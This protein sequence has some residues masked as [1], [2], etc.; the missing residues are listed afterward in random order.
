ML[1]LEGFSSVRHV[2]GDDRLRAEVFK[3]FSVVEMQEEVLLVGRQF[4]LSLFRPDDVRVFESVGKVVDEH[5]FQ[6][7]GFAVFVLHVNVVAFDVAVENPFR[8]V[9]F[10]RLLFHGYQERP[11]FFLGFR[12][13]HI[14]E[15]ERKHAQEE[16]EEHYGTHDAQQRDARCL[17]GKQFVSFAEVSE[18]H[19]RRQQNG[20][21]KRQ[22]YQRQRRQK[23]ELRKHVHFQSFPHQFVNVSPE[24]LHHEDEQA[25]KE[26]SGEEQQKA[27]ENKYVEF[28]YA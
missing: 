5:V 19:Q 25:D 20:Q 3:L 7:S 16:A 13:H 10:G 6:H 4:Q 15:K 24:E 23:K 1:F 28:L 8:N 14:L 22:R 9:H 27:L 12:P 26:C 18:C 2:S 21:R 11:Q 17:H